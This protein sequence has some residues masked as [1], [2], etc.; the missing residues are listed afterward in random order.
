MMTTTTSRAT[1]EAGHAATSPI[2]TAYMDRDGTVTPIDASWLATSPTLGDLVRRVNERPEHRG[3]FV[4][5]LAVDGEE[6]EVHADRT[7][8]DLPLVAVRELTVRCA[9][10]GP[11]MT[12]AIGEADAAVNEARSLF[13]DAAW[14]LRLGEGAAHDL[15]AEGAMR[16]TTVA[17]FI[18][19]ARQVMSGH[20]RAA[21]ELAR[22]RE[23]LH[24]ALRDAH[25]LQARRA[26]TELAD[27]IDT[28]LL[29][30]LEGW[31]ACRAA[32][33]QALIE[34]SFRP[35]IGAEF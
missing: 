5:G 16:L 11:A 3:V 34:P 20:G 6:V 35:A 24:A 13:G 17:A 15:L 8:Q 1:N 14:G 30:A 9:D 7:W 2:P 4:C 10:F 23:A 22:L 12:G 29:P 31:E 18:D 25:A 32:A 27:A 33:E 28:V 21:V 19:M 26:R